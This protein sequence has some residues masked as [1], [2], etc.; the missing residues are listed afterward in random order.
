MIEHTIRLG[1]IE[2]GFSGSNGHG[3]W[4]VWRV[5]HGDT[6]HNSFYPLSPQAWREP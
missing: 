1:P 3:L 5:D 6:C 4:W 2:F